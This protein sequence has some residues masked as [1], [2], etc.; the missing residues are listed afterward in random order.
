MFLISLVITIRQCPPAGVIPSTATP[1][2]AADAEDKQDYSQPQEPLPSAATSGKLSLRD[3]VLLKVVGQGSFGK[4]MQVR[5][6]DQGSIYAMK[7]LKKSHI[8]KRNQ[9]AHTKT[10]RNVLGRIK[11][12]FIVGLNYAFQVQC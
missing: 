2:S 6:K 11:H 12:P 4:V 9:V 1:A 7:V 10:E 8:V 3:F 5:K